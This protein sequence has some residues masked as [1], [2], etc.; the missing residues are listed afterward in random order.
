[1][2][3]SLN[4]LASARSARPRRRSPPGGPLTE[5][6]P[7]RRRTYNAVKV[8]SASTSSFRLPD[9]NFGEQRNAP[10]GN[11]SA[12]ALKPP[13]AAPA[14]QSFHDEEVQAALRD[15]AHRVADRYA[16]GLQR[17]CEEQLLWRRKHDERLRRKQ[18]LMQQ[19]GPQA[20]PKPSVIPNTRQGSKTKGGGLADAS[21]NFELRSPNY[22]RDISEA[23]FAQ[24]R[25]DQQSLPE[26]EEPPPTSRKLTRTSTVESRQM[27]TRRTVDLTVVTDR[28]SRTLE[29]DD[30]LLSPRT[31]MAAP[32]GSRLERAR[33]TLLDPFEKM[34]ARNSLLET[35]VQLEKDGHP[36][37]DSSKLSSSDVPMEDSL[38][39]KAPKLYFDECIALSKRHSVP[40]STLRWLRQEFTWLDGDGSGELTME[41]FQEALRDR[42]NLPPNEPIP[43]HLIDESFLEAD[44]DGNGDINFE[45][46][47]LWSL[48]HMFTEEMCVEDPK[49]RAV[50]T[51]AK[52]HNLPSAQVDEI[53]IIAKRIS[54][55]ESGA[56][57]EDEFRQIIAAVLKVDLAEVPVSR[58]RQ[59]W[60]EASRGSQRIEVV[61]IM[62]WYFNVFKGSQ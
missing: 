18:A 46:F 30:E 43:K 9:I 4:P 51:F 22:S 13:A 53:N 58:W 6:G 28:K 56:V 44:L 17:L 3:A 27:T 60:A 39:P 33:T 8:A 14:P 32:R 38:S 23:E 40:I 15:I 25:W 2:T 36:P 20:F 21:E 37:R 47:L 59:F 24:V 41:E 7:E 35:A 1:M 34:R 55:D 52:A 45:E 48:S 57:S 31:E 42:L 29:L 11:G 62:L 50:R 49:D 26:E 19:N 5:R 10:F 12:L 16:G 54:Q 61:D